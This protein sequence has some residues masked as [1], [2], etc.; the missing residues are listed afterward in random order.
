MIFSSVLAFFSSL[1]GLG[2]AGDAA[3]QT[4]VSR[5]VIQ[6]EMIV[7]VPVRPMTHALEWEEHKGPKCIDAEDIVG[8]R[9]SGP[10][11]VDFRMRDR[12]FIRAR[13]AADC[14]ALDFYGDFYLNPPDDRVCAK[15]DS[16][17]SRMGGSCRI[18]K[19][20]RVTPK[21]NH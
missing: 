21:F 17:R 15:R 12:S 9:L 20:Q 18:Q 11:Q 7:R 10:Q 1:L 6:E 13:F 2:E 19:F 5:T 16:I 4:T 8:A 14:P 3:V